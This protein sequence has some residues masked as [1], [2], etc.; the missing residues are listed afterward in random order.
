MNLFVRASGE[1]QRRPQARFALS[2][3]F[4]VSG[5]S[6]GVV[7]PGDA[8]PE[9]RLPGANI[10]RPFRAFRLLLRRYLRVALRLPERLNGEITSCARR[11]ILLFAALILAA[12]L[13]FAAEVQQSPVRAA[14][15]LVARVVPDAAQHFIVETIPADN[16]RDVFEVE[17]RGDKIVL[18]GNTPVSIASALNWYLENPCHCDI[19][20]N[21]GNQLKLPRPLPSLPEKIHVISPHQFRYAYNFCTYG[22]TMVWWDWPQFEHELDFL[23]L[24]GVNLALVIEGQEST[25]IQT[26]KNFGYSDK[27]V[28]Q[29]VVDPAH[30]PWMEMDN[31]E[32]YGGPLS[33][34]LV[35]RRLA[36]GQKI[37]ARMRELG[38]QPV[39][40][41][42]Y[43]MV[44]PDF[45]ERFPNA[46]VHPQGDWV[47]LK[48]PDILDPTD[49]MF[50][51][52][53]DAY[54]KAQ[55]DLFGG[56][57]FYDADPFHEGGSTNNI[58][59]PAAGRAI[60][61][62]MGDATWVLQ[63]WGLNPRPEMVNALD[64]DKIL[65]LDLFCDDHENWRLR[66]NFDG[67]P[68]LW[69][70]VN[71]F[72]GNMKVGGRLAWMAQG[73][74]A[75][76]TDLHRGRMSG[77]GALMEGTGVNPALWE[78]FWEDSWR[79]DAPDMNSWL[80]QYAE[81]RYGAKIP[82]AEQ[83]WKILIETAYDEPPAGTAH[84]V[85]P[86]VCSRPTLIQPKLP[87]VMLQ[88]V[89]NRPVT[90]LHYDP[91]R[92]VEAWRLLL[93]AAPQAQ[94]SDAYRFDLCDVGRQV[95]ANLSARYNRQI[96]A[97]YR[98]HDARGLRAA[99]AK[100]L[101]LIRDMDELA[102]TRREWLLGVWLADARSW[103][104]TRKERD[105]CERNARELLTTWTRYDNITDYANRQWNGLLGDFYYHRWQMWLDA[106]NNSVDN[107]TPLDEKAVNAEIRE[108]EVSWTQQTDGHYLTNPRG[109]S[110]AISQKLYDRYASDAS[111]PNEPEK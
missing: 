65:V 91:E 101:G 62:A 76:L 13:S 70:V 35:A 90:T 87:S 37:V 4:A 66:N 10:V 97:A 30:L 12:N 64:K 5:L 103:G 92:L 105:L 9:S 3:G 110:V 86:V 18:R 61:S 59:V 81:R 11:V 58:D 42:Y 104:A 56:A 15:A 71:C 40:P 49:P 44:P 75:A 69:C 46:N 79:A 68:W 67:S 98:A 84:T 20:W 33:A 27:A 19:S 21:A 29:W 77:I 107:N 52:V 63:S 93:D 95:L 60:Q 51:R 111:T 41:G 100:M 109:D 55:Q 38:I 50:A 1:E 85:K 88:P 25:W 45:H 89:Q 99:S 102:G 23:A 34:Q 7:T 36:L 73:P 43:G 72:G 17:S 48:R 24:K 108:W 83:A 94:S 31:M 22:Y 16:G 78:M 74:D 57:D 28:R 32:S 26:F 53:A 39:L 106:L 47:K 6:L 96:I 14:E 2:R 8:L 54:Y 82:A 80:D